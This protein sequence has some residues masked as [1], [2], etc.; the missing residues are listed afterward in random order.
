MMA[1][2][3]DPNRL[4]LDLVPERAR[5]WRVTDEGRVRVLEPRY[6][7]GPIGR[8]LA[9]RLTRPNIEIRLDDIGSAVWQACDGETS[10]GEIAERLR[11]RFGERVEPAR[12]R[13]GTFLRQMEHTHMIRMKEP[14]GRR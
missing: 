7:S 12:D 9:T 6:G 10:V 2:A 1:A 5:E 8:W 11:E 14:N 3:N 4:D 13:L